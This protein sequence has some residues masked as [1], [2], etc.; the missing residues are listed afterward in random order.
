VVNGKQVAILV[1]TTI[2]ALQ[3]YKTISERLKDF[4]VKVD[5]VNRFKTLGQRKKVFEELKKG[6]V[7][8][9]IGTHALLNKNVGFKDLGLLVIDEEQKFG[10]A[11]KEKLRGLKVNVDTLTLTATPIP[12]TLHNQNCSAQSTTDSYRKKNH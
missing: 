1:P 2:L 9:V 3:H 7:D 10:V 6:N 11:A 4:P 5:Y 8:I 12:R